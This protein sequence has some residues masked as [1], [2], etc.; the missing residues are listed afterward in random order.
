MTRFLAW[1]IDVALLVA[2]LMIARIAAGIVGIVDVGIAVGFQLAFNFLVLTAYPIVLEW[3]WR[4]RTVGKRMMGLRVVD[5]QGFKLRFEQVVLRNLLRIVDRLPLFYLV[6]GLS[7]ILTRRNQRLGDIAAGTIVTY[8]AKT[9]VPNVESI[10]GD[11]YNSLRKHPHLEAR[12]RHATPP[13]AAALALDAIARRD[14]FDPDE[15]LSVFKQFADYFR[16]LVSFPDED[17]IGI[18]DEQY[19]RNVVDTIYNT[20]AGKRRSAATSQ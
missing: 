17:V 6:G 12:L 18:G 2:I 8:A 19:V 5:E 1:A 10:M 14:D 16:D 11:K 7:C 13:L 4:G 9:S 20:R 15:R 3:F